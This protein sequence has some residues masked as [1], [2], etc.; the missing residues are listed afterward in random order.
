VLKPGGWAILQVPIGRKETFEDSTITTFE[1]R[2][3]VFG[4]GGAVRN[5]GL[6]YID[7]L[8]DAGFTVQVLKFSKELGEK[9]IDKYGLQKEN[10][11]L[12]LK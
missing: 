2:E 4:C 9:K 3:V 8:R 1:K 11:Y 6:D 10:L 7:R 5:Y 12:C